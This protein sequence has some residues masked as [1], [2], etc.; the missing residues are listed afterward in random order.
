VLTLIYTSGTTGPPK[1]VQLTHAN[2]VAECR[3]VAEVL[4]IRVGGR[5]TS[6]LPSAHLADRWSAYYHPSIMCGSTITSVPDPRQVVAVLPE[7]RPTFWGAVPRIWEKMK[8]ALEA[9]GVVDPAAM[10]AEGRAAVRAK[11]GLDQ[12]DCL[13][14]GA[15]GCR[16]ASSGGCPSCPAA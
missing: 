15:A 11:L 10:P 13:I 16:S 8:A 12:A 6:Y 5:G 14:S 2:M 3:A 1:G 9:Q 7:V 4:P